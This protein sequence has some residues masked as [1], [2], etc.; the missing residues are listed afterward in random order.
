[1][2]QINHIIYVIISIVFVECRQLNQS[3]LIELYGYS[4]NSF[5]IDLSGLSFDAIDLGT[6]VGFNNL[7]I[8][9]LEDNKISKIEQGLFNDVRNLRELWLESNN[10]NSIN[11]NAFVGLNSLE[12]VCLDN[13]PISTL[14]P[15]SLATI[16]ETNSKCKVKIFEKCIKISTSLTTTSTKGN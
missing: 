2:N 9:Y 15:N 10:I 8:I 14:F 11:R 13:N 6:F 1:M 4:I 5:Q 16:C 3:I 12:L 7:E